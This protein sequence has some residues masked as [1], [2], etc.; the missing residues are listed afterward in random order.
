MRVRFLNSKDKCYA[1]EYVWARVASQIP[2]YFTISFLADYI[3]HLGCLI[4]I[5]S[6][7]CWCHHISLTHSIWICSQTRESLVPKQVAQWSRRKGTTPTPA[8]NKPAA[9]RPR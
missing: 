6:I 5:I 7:F 2:I 8:R 9:D 3:S 4:V 1:L